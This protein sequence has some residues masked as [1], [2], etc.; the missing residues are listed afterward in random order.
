M[1]LP[2]T[3]TLGQVVQDNG[4]NYQWT[5]V[6]WK[7]IGQVT[8]KIGNT[9]INA[10]GFAS[11]NTVVGGNGVSV[12]NTSIGGNGVSIGNTS[13]NANGF[14]SG[15]TSVGANGFTSG[16]TFVGA[17][18]FTSGNTSIGG[19]G[20]SVGNTTI[21]ANGFT[22]NTVV[23]NTAITGN[24]IS[25]G[26]STSNTAITGNGVNTGNS[27]T[28]TAITGN[29]VATGNS[30]SNT[31]ISGNGIVIGTGDST[32]TINSSSFS[33]TANN[34][35]RL[36]GVLATYYINTSANYTI[37]GIHT[38]N[39]NVNINRTII[40]NGDTGS[41]GQVLTSGGTGNIYWSTASGGGGGSTNV[42]A[43]YTW[44][45]T[46]T[47]SNTIT[48]SSTIN[49]T[50]NN[51]LYLN[52]TI[53]SGYQTTAGLSANIATLSSNNASYLGTVAA[54]SYVQNTD[55]RVLSGN[56]NF[57]GA[58]SYFSGKTTHAANL[59]LNAG[60]SIIDSTGS[61]G[62]ANQVLASNG[63]G[64]VY[65]KDVSSGGSWTG[66][67]LSNTAY[68]SN[69]A[70]STNATS[71]AITVLGGVGVANNIYTAGRYGFSNTSN[72]GVAYTVYN[73]T[74]NTI[75]TVFG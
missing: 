29:G 1:A 56:L 4:Y 62:T 12:G 33:G 23:G 36:G 10:N 73:E 34:S 3:G 57:T 58:N 55:S 17:N 59:V 53:A 50:A 40:I 63:S 16:N 30:T 60:I 64:N 49:G 47:F 48:F 32:A 22:G 54:A 68:F 44:T 66:G 14:T 28:N 37:T 8:I 51:A 15:N 11:G 35:L 69:T 26:N 24:S 41:A 21:G 43:Q 65:W 71:G 39:A 42:D 20:V 46:Q 5:G 38:Y 19:N 52:G 13:L 7:N 70:A 9:V 45:N 67:T 6:G 74:L 25:T 2:R 75:D 31:S 18:G 72:I 61:Q 27:T